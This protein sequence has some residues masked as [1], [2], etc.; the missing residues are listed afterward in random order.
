[1]SFNIGK[2]CEHAERIVVKAASTVHPKDL[3]GLALL[4]EKLQDQFV[5]GY[6]LYT[7]PTARMVADRVTALPIDVLWR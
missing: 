4:R 7:G 2:K 3:T 5:G 1:M 6:V